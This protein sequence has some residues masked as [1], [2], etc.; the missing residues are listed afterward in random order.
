[1]LLMFDFQSH[2]L[3]L[4]FLKKVLPNYHL[5]RK[6]TFDPKKIKSEATKA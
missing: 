6:P 1:M 3:Q 4:D 2:S 5:L